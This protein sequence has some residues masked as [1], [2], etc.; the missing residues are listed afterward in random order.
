MSQRCNSLVVCKYDDDNDVNADGKGS[1]DEHNDED[2]HTDDGYFPLCSTGKEPRLQGLFPTHVE[3]P[4]H[5]GLQQP[6]QGDGRDGA[7]GRP[8]RTP[9]TQTASVL[10]CSNPSLVLP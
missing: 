4:G 2:A 10:Y 6:V 8:W 5:N 1:D 9:S 3:P 7:G